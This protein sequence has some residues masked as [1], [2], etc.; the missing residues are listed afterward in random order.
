MSQGVHD[1]MTKSFSE[2]VEAFV[3]ELAKVDR[4]GRKG[5]EMELSYWIKAIFPLLKTVHGIV[6]DDLNKYWQTLCF[7]STIDVFIKPVQQ[8]KTV[9]IYYVLSMLPPQKADFI[10]GKIENLTSAQ[11]QDLRS[12]LSKKDK[13]GFIQVLRQTQFKS[14]SR[15]CKV[16]GSFVDLKYGLEWGKNERRDFLFKA[17][18]KKLIPSN[19][20]KIT[21]EFYNCIIDCYTFFNSRYASYKRSCD[22]SLANVLLAIA[23]SLHYK[24]F[25]YFL[26]LMHIIGTKI[27]Y[28]LAC[29][30]LEIRNKLSQNDLDAIYSILYDADT[31]EYDRILNE[32]ME[33]DTPMELE[34]FKRRY[35]D[36]LNVKHH[37]Q[38]Y[39]YFDE[40]ELAGHHKRYKM[41]Q[42]QD[43]LR[44]ELGY[45]G[46]Q[47]DLIMNSYID[48]DSSIPRKDLVYSPDKEEDLTVDEN[49]SIMPPCN[50]DDEEP[51]SIEPQPE[52]LS[53]ADYN[54]EIPEKFTDE[55]KNTINNFF[56]K[57]TYFK[58]TPD[59][60][61]NYCT[62]VNKKF[63]DL[64]EV[65]RARKFEA[66]IKLLAKQR[67]IAPINVVMQSCAYD[68]TGIGFKDP[69]EHVPV[70]WNKE[71]VAV[72]LFICTKFFK[73]GKKADFAKPV[74]MFHVED[75]YKAM[76][77]PS[78]AA[79]GFNDP[80]FLMK[81]QKIFGEL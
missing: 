80:E 9:D 79:E 2:L 14:I 69:Y 33:C 3:E 12:H 61:P 19:E 7:L 52:Q 77:N 56:I 50:Q 62:I 44:Y 68:F 28:C 78:A 53:A 58:V 11:F 27:Y 43:S 26:V 60:S 63:N 25:D 71:K 55:Q 49:T 24:T 40:E 46:I 75:V 10:L 15:M 65:E 72:L 67:C 66:F 4:A 36:L 41:P 35:C 70:F 30:F 51:A 32:Y 1:Q 22:G 42:L 8:Y 31:K 37:T 16:L 73:K 34:E 76:Q 64:D 38:T 74:K 45:T 59:K 57:D 13:Y 20:L 18:G 47:W 6:N 39:S 21:D 23:L 48:S 54:Q 17:Y 5:V 81:F 29:L